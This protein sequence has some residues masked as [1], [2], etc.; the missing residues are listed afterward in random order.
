VTFQAVNELGTR[1]RNLVRIPMGASSGGAPEKDVIA[2]LRSRY[3]RGHGPLL[4]FVGRLVEEKGV[5]D[6]LHAVSLLLP[7]LPGISTVIV[8]DGPQRQDLERLS[9]ELGITARVFFAGWIPSADIPGYLAAGDVFVGPSKRG[10]DGTT[11]AQ[12]LAFIEAMLAGTPVIAS[13]VGGIVDAVRNES[14]GLLVPES[15]PEDIAAAVKRLVSDSSLRERLRESAR[16]LAAR[17]LTREA[18]ARAFSMLFERVLAE[19]GRTTGGPR[20][21]VKDV[22]S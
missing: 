8:G 4:V 7:V 17:E 11:E 21:Q 6:L 12:G 15:S 20:T 9:N 22:R 5:A 16:E 10:C 1:H 13:A 3:L 18:S 2:R 14:T 19:R